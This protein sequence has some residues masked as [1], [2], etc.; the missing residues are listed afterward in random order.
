MHPVTRHAGNA[1]ANPRADA[2]SIGD[3]GLDANMRDHLGAQLRTM[4]QEIVTEP[5]PD[6][7]QRL[8]NELARKGRPA[9][10]QK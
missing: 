4:F 1:V 7:F 3:H 8:L 5:L 9:D 6:R 10:G 2:A